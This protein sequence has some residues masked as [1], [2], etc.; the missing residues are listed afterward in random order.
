MIIP[1]W[2]VGAVV[3]IAFVSVA[4]VVAGWLGQPFGWQ[5]SDR[6]RPPAQRDVVP[7]DV[8]AGEVETMQRR[9]AELEERLDFAERL[10]AQRRD[11]ERVAPPKT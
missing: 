11:A 2:A 9:I 8:R 6:K 10:L 5:R 3:I 4:H 7:D 1:D